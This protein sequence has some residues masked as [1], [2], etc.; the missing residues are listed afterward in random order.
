MIYIHG[1]RDIP[2]SFLGSTNKY[3]IQ[4]DLLNQRVKI[5]LKFDNYE[6]LEKDLFKIVTEKIKVF[7]FFT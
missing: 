3:S 1:M 2:A 5:P 4:Y 6:M 7:Y